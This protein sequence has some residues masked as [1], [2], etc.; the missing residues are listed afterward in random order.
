[1]KKILT[2]GKLMNRVKRA[3]AIVAIVLTS[4]TSSA[5]L[6]NVG[7]VEWDPD[8]IFD[9]NGVAGLIYQEIDLGTGDL[10][11]Y[12]RVTTLNGLGLAALCPGCE[13][14][15]HFG[16]YT[17]SVADSTLT[18]DLEYVGGW[19]KFWVDNTVDAPDSDASLLTSA[20]TGDDGGTNA[21]WLE[22]AGHVIGGTETTFIGGFDFTGFPT[23]VGALDV[24]GGM[25]MGNTDT[26]SIMLPNQTITDITFGSTFTNFGTTG[27][28]S[29]GTGSADFKGNSIPE[30][31]SLAIFGLALIALAIGVRNSKF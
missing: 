15:F 3:L 4:F 18:T 14:T 16:G 26:D 12:G 6:I 8:Y 9:F 2:E 27:T 11:G 7:G 5:S 13:L 25:A 28:T 22:L 29:W 30:P 24:V 20:N 31:A 23:G 21:L 17:L 1:M 10:S 19:M